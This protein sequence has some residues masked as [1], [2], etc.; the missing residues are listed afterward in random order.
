MTFIARDGR[1]FGDSAEAPGAVATMENHASRPEVIEA[2]EHGLGTAR[3]H[4]DTINVDML[5]VAVP[6][7]HPS[8]AFVRVAL[9]LTDIRQQFRGVLTVT[10]AALGLALL[11][12]AAIGWL[13]SSRIGQRVRDDRRRSPA[14]TAPA[15]C[16]PRASTS[17]TTSWASSRARST[18][19]CRSSGGSSPNR[20]A[21]ARAWRPS[22]PA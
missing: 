12:A 7:V 17:A 1:V 15:I 10:V 5:Y 4:S 13:F 16:R 21:I 6:V 9:P 18:T 19:R 22:S 8:I 2:R 20:R 14:A 3:R 11:G